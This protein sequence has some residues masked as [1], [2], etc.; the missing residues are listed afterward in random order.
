MIKKRMLALVL[1]AI[2][3]LWAPASALAAAPNSIV[4]SGRDATVAAGTEV[5]SVVVISG[6]AHI[7]GRVTETVVVIGG[8]IYLEPGAE[9]YGDAVSLGGTINLQ[10]D[11]RIG[12]QQVSM[13]S[14]SLD[15][16][17]V[18]PFFSN[19]LGFNLSVWRLLSL[20]FLGLVVFWL[21]PQHVQRS[22]AALELN[23]LRS[24]IF[25]LLGYLALVP[26]TILLL[27]TVLGIPLIPLLWLMVIAGRLLGQVSLGLLAGRWLAPKL[28][29]Q[30]TEVYQILLGLLVLG[31]I[32]AIPVVGG[33]A[34]LFYGLVGFGAVL[35]TRFGTRA[36]S[37]PKE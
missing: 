8:S 24:V 35:W 37:L 14:F 22:N 30:V 12:G 19:W 20:L 27:I 2:V 1:V 21:L 10:G 18:G 34:S 13:G 6:D 9:V 7:A 4:V 17:H 29:L 23:P 15:N 28:N 26:M 31:L 5:D 32:T 11:A 33:L 25:G 16:I 3:C 36:A